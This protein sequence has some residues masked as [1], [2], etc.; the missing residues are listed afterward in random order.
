MISVCIATYNG[1][2]YIR[3]QLESILAQIA[4]EDE[5][6]ISDDGSDDDTV[7]VI[8][9]LN[10]CRIRLFRHNGRN[11]KDNFAYAMSQSRGDVIF[12][13]DQDDIW[14][15]DKY[16][17]CTEALQNADLVLTNCKVVDAELNTIMPSFFDAYHSKPGLL[18]NIL[19][20]A[21]YGSCMAF[22]RKIY[23]NSLP[24]PSSP[25][26]T[27]DLWL[28][29]VAEMTGRVYFISDICMLYRRHSSTVTT[30]GS[31]L[32]TRSKRSLWVKIYTRI[33]L[34]YYV[35]HYKIMNKA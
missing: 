10:D 15:P 7:A 23:N 24:W 11:L 14:L 30:V 4:D 33:V 18:R 5:I 20:G 25:L 27:H 21:Y 28:G 13:S 3:Q 17:L 26:V 19:A 1:A 29:L 32:W 31:N 8:E 34:F 6:I 9:Q 12:L 35:L 16:R 2:R 22:R